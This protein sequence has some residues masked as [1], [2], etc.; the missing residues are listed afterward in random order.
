[1]KLACVFCIVLSFSSCG[2]GVRKHIDI[3][4]TQTD[5]ESIESAWIAYSLDNPEL[6]NEFSIIDPSA[7][8]IISVLLGKNSSDLKRFNQVSKVY[9]EFPQL[10]SNGIPIDEWGQKYEIKI[11][12]KY[13]AENE[14]FV[15]SRGKNGIDEMGGGDDVRSK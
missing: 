7:A 10:P 12:R 4:R 8:D 6:A 15:Y 3:G 2:V 1:M 14:I 9:L 13:G 5:I 11:I